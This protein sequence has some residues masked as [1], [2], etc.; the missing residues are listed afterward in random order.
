[1]ALWGWQWQSNTAGIVVF[2][3]AISLNGNEI[4]HKR[5]LLGMVGGEI[6]GANQ[7]FTIINVR[8]HARNAQI[9]A[10]Y[11]DFLVGRPVVG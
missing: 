6:A 1:M 8:V 3:A 2:F 10:E 11:L 5:V 9:L 7:V 4:E